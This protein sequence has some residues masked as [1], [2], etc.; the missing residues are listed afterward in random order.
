[1]PSHSRGL[2]LIACVLAAPL[3]VGCSQRKAITPDQ[4][5]SAIRQARSLAAE[6]ELFVDFVLQGSATQTYAEGH[7]A[8]LEEQIQ[9]SAAQ[10][11]GDAAEPDTRKSLRICRA[12]LLRLARELSRVQAAIRDPQALVAARSSIAGIREDLDTAGRPL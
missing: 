9:D 3:F 10:L 12:A 8:Y 6:S 2:C 5:R 4:L 1:M 7:A 11:T